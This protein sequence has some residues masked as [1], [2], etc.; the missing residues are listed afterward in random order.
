M[1]PV[2]RIKD[3]VVYF[4]FYKITSTSNH[5]SSGVTFAH[6]C[7]HNKNLHAHLS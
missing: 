4:S 6:L 1:T 3:K 2:P 5:P 7:Y